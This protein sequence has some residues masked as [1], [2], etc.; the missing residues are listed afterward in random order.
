MTSSIELAVKHFFQMCAP[1]ICLLDGLDELPPGILN[2]RVD[3]YEELAYNYTKQN[4]DEP[5]SDFYFLYLEFIPL[6]GPPPIY[7]LWELG[8]STPCETHSRD[9]CDWTIVYSRTVNPN[10]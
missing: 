7:F 8:V 4:P 2:I 6:H 5:D 3:P 1:Y 9:V 10:Q